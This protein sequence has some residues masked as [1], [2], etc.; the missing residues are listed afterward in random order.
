MFGGLGVELEEGKVN[1]NDTIASVQ[2]TLVNDIRVKPIG[3]L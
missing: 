3:F 2:W 1:L